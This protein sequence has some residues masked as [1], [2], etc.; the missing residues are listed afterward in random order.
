MRQSNG[1]FDPANGH[2]SF[3]I[4]GAGATFNREGKSPGRL[5]IAME[6]NMRKWRRCALGI[7]TTL[8]SSR[9]SHQNEALLC[10]TKVTLQ[11]RDRRLRR[12]NENRSWAPI[13]SSVL[14]F[15]QRP[16]E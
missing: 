16:L 13:A 11:K 10:L 5:R 1:G 6:R 15:D 14:C 2:I 7:R 3:R 4:D 9:T 8:S 12:N